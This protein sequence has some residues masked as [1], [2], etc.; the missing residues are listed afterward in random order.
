MWKDVREG[1]ASGN[2]YDNDKQWQDYSASGSTIKI[3]VNRWDCLL[4]FRFRWLF[5]NEFEISISILIRLEPIEGLIFRATVTQRYETVIFLM[6][7]FCVTEI[8]FPCA[9]NV[10]IM[11]MWCWCWMLMLITD[12]EYWCIHLWAAA[13]VYTYSND[14]PFRARADFKFTVSCLKS[15]Q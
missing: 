3:H 8:W 13:V 14:R 6:I 15:L 12:Y 2:G 9:S 4:Y 1:A 5:V 7:T 10:Q 11:N